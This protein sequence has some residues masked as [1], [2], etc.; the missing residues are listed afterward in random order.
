M[1][2]GGDA[3]KAGRVVLVDKNHMMVQTKDGM[4][5]LREVQLEGKKRMEID[6]FL[7]GNKVEEGVILSS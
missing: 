3:A 1:V 7:R 4:L 2:E 5:S 6:A